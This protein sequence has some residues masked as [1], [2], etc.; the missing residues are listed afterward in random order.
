MS[1]SSLREQAVHNIRRRRNF[2]VEV[3]GA[4]ILVIVMVI[5]WALTGGGYFW[6][7][8]VALGCAI[9]LVVQGLKLWGPRS[10]PI[11]DADVQSEMKRLQN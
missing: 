1:D 5:I 4:V 2:G 11:S 8:W 6:P 10:R 3:G 7:A 9:A